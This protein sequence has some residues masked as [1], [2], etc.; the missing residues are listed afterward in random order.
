MDINPLIKLLSKN[1]KILVSEA[2]FQFAIA[3]EIKQNMPQAE[4]RLEYCPADIDKSMHVDVLVKNNGL[5][6]PVELKYM[7]LGCD[8]IVNE[9]RYF[10]KNQGAQDIR[11]YDFLKDIMR[12]EKLVSTG[13]PF[14]KGFAVLLTNDRSYWTVSNISNTCDAAFR[15]NEGAKKNGILRWGDHTGTGTSKGRE[16]PI[17]LAGTY[18]MHWNDFSFIDDRR[19]GQFRYLTVE[20]F[21]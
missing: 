9:E 1:R 16:E 7:T 3:W 5:W 17:V 8:V 11:R 12:I 6:Y 10:L 15:I 2:D 14:S 20:V 18:E 4:V 21:K 19:W 13:S